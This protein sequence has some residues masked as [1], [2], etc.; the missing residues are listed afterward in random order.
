[1]TIGLAT[2]LPSLL[3][4]FGKG[5]LSF[6]FKVREAIPSGLKTVARGAFVVKSR[7]FDASSN[8]CQIG[9]GPGR[10]RDA[11]LRLPC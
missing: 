11:S 6:E 8:C 5:F 1:M 4:D 7:E 10:A 3:G 2:N 9:G